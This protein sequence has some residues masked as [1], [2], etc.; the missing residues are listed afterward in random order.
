M[1]TIKQVLMRRDHLTAEE[2]EDLIDDAR[3]ALIEYLEEDDFDSAEN[4]CEEF[5]GLEPDYLE[6][7]APGY[8]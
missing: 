6:E 1:E 7:L 3:R 8:L 4:V 5:F 2:A